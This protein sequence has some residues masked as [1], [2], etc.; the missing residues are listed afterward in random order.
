MVWFN[1]PSMKKFSS[2]FFG[3]MYH[4]LGQY[5]E[6]FLSPPRNF[7]PVCLNIIYFM[8]TCLKV[9]YKDAGANWRAER[10]NIICWRTELSEKIGFLVIGV[11]QKSLNVIPVYT[12]HGFH[13]GV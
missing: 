10:E 7:R 2:T 9:Q 3:D 4:F 1:A 13:P 6:I 11:R 8:F 5:S 12:K